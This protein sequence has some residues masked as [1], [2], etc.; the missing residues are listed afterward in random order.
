[1]TNIDR[2][3]LPSQEEP[4]TLGKPLVTIHVDSKPRTPDP[5][6]TF[7]G[8]PAQQGQFDVRVTLQ[9]TNF[10]FPRV[11]AIQTVET[12]KNG[13]ET[14]ELYHDP[15]VGDAMAAAMFRHN[16]PREAY[17]D[18]IISGQVEIPTQALPNSQSPR[19]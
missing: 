17:I 10:L 1:M 13:T 15:E 9:G 5:P 14:T 11:W 18:D 12:D 19:K 4:D 16:W 7:R 3:R 6:P 2:E 8:F